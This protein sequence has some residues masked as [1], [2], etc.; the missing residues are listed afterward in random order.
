MPVDMMSSAPAVFASPFLSA[1]RPILRGRTDAQNPNN[2]P[3]LLHSQDF[4][5]PGNR[6]HHPFG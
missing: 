3:D 4:P 6:R 2:P 1:M 5:S